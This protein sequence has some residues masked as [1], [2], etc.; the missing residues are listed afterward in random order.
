MF[1]RT[2]SHRNLSIA[3]LAMHAVACAE[4]APQPTSA[5]PPMASVSA[6]ASTAVAAEP[7]FEARAVGPLTNAV[8]LQ[9]VSVFS[10]EPGETL[11]SPAIEI[12][13]FVADAREKKGFGKDALKSML[14]TPTP[15]T[16]KANQLLVIAWGPRSEFSIARAK[17]M[18]HTAM[19]A[20]IES[21]VSDM[22]YAPIARDQGV[23]TIAADE[24]AAAF[25]EGALTEFSTEQNA[26]ATKPMKLQHVTYEAGAAF[27]DAVTKAVSRGVAASH[28]SIAPHAN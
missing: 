28:A 11:I 16:I 15:A 13:S 25:V 10:Y 19:R 5:T 9:I 4:S 2:P 23:T 7:T 12:A 20:T 22:A 6:P 17:E 14:V 18:G 21:G 24:V 3:L 8:P 26:G 27:V 1:A